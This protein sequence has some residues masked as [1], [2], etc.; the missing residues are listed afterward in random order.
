[1]AEQELAWLLRRIAELARE[2]RRK[3]ERESMQ[4]GVRLSSV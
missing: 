4:Y 2:M 1:M 3:K